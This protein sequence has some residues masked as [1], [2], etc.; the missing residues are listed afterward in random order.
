MGQAG[1]PHTCNRPCDH[2]AR[3]SLFTKIWKRSVSSIKE[4]L[5]HHLLNRFF[6]QFRI[7]RSKG[8]SLPFSSGMV[9][10]HGNLQLPFRTHLLKDA[11]L[12]RVHGFHVNFF[13]IATSTISKYQKNPSDKDNDNGP[14]SY[15]HP[16]YFSIEPYIGIS[17]GHDLMDGLQKTV[18]N[19]TVRSE[20]C[21]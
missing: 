18:Y 1:S 11:L 5:F 16:E 9:Q 21:L 15:N 4:C 3:F 6:R 14:T 7:A 10:T 20:H 8:R 19:V 12:Y 17:G 2:I 13:R